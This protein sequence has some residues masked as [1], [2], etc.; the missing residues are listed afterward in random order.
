MF[1]GNP[2]CALGGEVSDLQPLSGPWDVCGQGALRHKG[3]CGHLWDQW[4]ARRE[5]LVLPL[6]LSCRCAIKRCLFCCCCCFKRSFLTVIDWRLP[7]WEGCFGCEFSS[8]V[9]SSA[10]SGSGQ[11]QFFRFFFFSHDPVSSSPVRASGW[12]GGGR[13]GVPAS[14]TA[15]LWSGWQAG[16]S[17]A[18]PAASLGWQGRDRG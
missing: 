13:W 12:G 9:T 6:Q 16:P 1:L 18:S 15:P 10:P 3:P 2:Q 17:C 14:P 7:S 11:C 4:K 8:T 5:F